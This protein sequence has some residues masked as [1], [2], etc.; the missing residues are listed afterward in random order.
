M[1]I[2]A[3]PIPPTEGFGEA[4]GFLIKFSQND[5]RASWNVQSQPL[6][7]I[8]LV[9]RI[10]TGEVLKAWISES[11]ASKLRT[12]SIEHLLV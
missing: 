4:I 10:E 1:D 2:K 6:L 12:V 8:A 5:G 7:A 3:S 9:H 11:V